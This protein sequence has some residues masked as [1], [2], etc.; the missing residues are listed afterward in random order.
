M[1]IGHELI[2]VGRDDCESPQPFARSWLFQFS[3]MPAMPKG[4]PFFKAI[5]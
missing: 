3:Q 5:A 2:G 1:D 4:A